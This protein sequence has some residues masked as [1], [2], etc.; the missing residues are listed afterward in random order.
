MFTKISMPS[1]SPTME[2]GKIVSWIKKINDEIESGE[3]L[4]EV[5]TDKATMEYEA[6]DDGY[7]VKIIC[8]VGQTV[9]VNSLVAV[10]SE[11][12]SFNDEDL[13]DFLSEPKITEDKS[14]VTNDKL[15]TN[16]DQNK[17]SQ[18]SNNIKLT[19]LAKRVSEQNDINISSIAPAGRKIRVNDLFQNKKVNENKSRTFI[20]PAAKV[21]SIN[22]NINIKDIIGSG[23]DNR[24]ILRDLNLTSATNENKLRKAI[25]K[26]TLYSKQNIP[27]FY[28]NSKVRMDNL[29]EF[30]KKHKLSGNRYSLNSLMIFAIS[31]SFKAFPQANCTYSK[32]DEFIVNNNID[33]GLA[34]DS[35][36]GLKMPVLKNIETMDLNK[37]S[38]SL[39]NLI[40]SARSNSLTPDDLK[41]GT[42]SISNLG[43]FNIRSFDAIIFPGQTYILSVGQIFE[44][45]VVSKGDIS[46]G[47]F[48]NLTLACDH[49]AVDGV[50]AAKFFSNIS[51]TME[52]IK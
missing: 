28:L 19:S 25:A 21:I 33:I 37:L 45:V 42:I 20:S 15:E 24:I 47:N 10:I 27:H 41:G 14:I 2:E 43:S 32:N 5:E 49:R 6:P 31:E 46:T 51:N 50:L 16:I 26:A 29:L 30:R 35:D 38:S 8:E 13:K 4:F 48:M 9:S 11:S 36:A 52:K 12:K 40:D 39:N 44:D 18:L 17:I 23:P 3:V 34:V 7:L 1:L 22:N